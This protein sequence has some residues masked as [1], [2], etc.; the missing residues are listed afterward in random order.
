MPLKLK[1]PCANHDCPNLAE[2]GK[3]FCHIHQQYEDRLYNRLA[4]AN[5]QDRD[6]WSSANWR[7]KR[8]AVLR[9][10]PFC[11]ICGKPATEVDHI[12]PLRKGGTDDNFNLRAL[13]K[14]CHSSKSARDGRWGRG[15]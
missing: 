15:H 11:S 4:R 12:I 6:Y 2:P 7:K 5:G 10:H 3:R 9:E 13:C 8:A 14:K 1:H